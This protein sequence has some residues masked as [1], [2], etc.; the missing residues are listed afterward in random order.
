MI[1]KDLKELVAATI[2]IADGDLLNQKINSAAEE[3]WNSVDLPG[4]LQ[5]DFFNLGD[6][7]IIT[8]PYYV[9]RIRKVKPCEFGVNTTVEGPIPAYS[10]HYYS[11]SPWKWRILRETPLMRDIEEASTLEIRPEIPLESDVLISLAG[12]TDVADRGQETVTLSAGES[13]VQ[14][15]MRYE[16]LDLL[17]KHSKTAANLRVY[18]AAGNEVAFLPNHIL[19]ARNTQIQVY[20]RCDNSFLNRCLAVLYK[21]VL[22]YMAEDLDVFPEPYGQALLIKVLEWFKIDTKES[23][24]HAS[25][26]A[27]KSSSMFARA[28]GDFTE[29]QSKPMQTR[30][31]PFQKSSGW[32]GL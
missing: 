6:T 10:D 8:L 26:Y 2:S 11:N 22:P 23:L 7:A 32:K 19:P 1:F 29:G 14:T 3:I 25:L 9:Y 4:C 17:Q 31:S 28:S 30:R 21:P 20:S 5:E 16:D 27:T 12:P 13:S 24:E 18:D 15:T